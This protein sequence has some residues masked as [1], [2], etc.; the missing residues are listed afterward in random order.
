MQAIICAQVKLVKQEARNN[1][2]YSQRH[3]LIFE[4]VPENKD[5]DSKYLISH[6]IETHLGLKGA[7]NQIDKAHRMGPYRQTQPRPIIVRFKT[8]N[9]KEITYRLLAGTGLFINLHLDE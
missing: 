4:K 5:E 6:L 3:N 9:A 2:A 1:T 8:H 7:F